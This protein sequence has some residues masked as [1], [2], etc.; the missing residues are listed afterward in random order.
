MPFL[1]HPLT[2]AGELFFMRASCV[3]KKD[4]PSLASLPVLYYAFMK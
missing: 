4:L 3:I 1:S 2:V